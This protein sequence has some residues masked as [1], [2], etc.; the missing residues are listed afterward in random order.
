[1]LEGVGVSLSP[2][3]PELQGREKLQWVLWKVRHSQNMEA[4]VV[5]TPPR[6]GPGTR[7]V[8]FGVG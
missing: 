8:G 1:M 7:L 2:F 5:S 6:C 3:L 4:R